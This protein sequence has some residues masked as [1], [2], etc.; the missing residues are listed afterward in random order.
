M[1]TVNSMKARHIQFTYENTVFCLALIQAPNK[2]GF[3]IGTCVNEK[4]NFSWT[5]LK[6]G[7]LLPTFQLD[8]PHIHP[9][10]HLED[11]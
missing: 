1:Y 6:I 4:E 9:H 10:I 8:H 7:K 5:N 2:G 3:S 11:D